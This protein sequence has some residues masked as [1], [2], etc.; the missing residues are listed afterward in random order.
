MHVWQLGLCLLW[1]SSLACSTASELGLFV[2]TFATTTP[3][4]LLHR[5][6]YPSILTLTRADMAHGFQDKLS[7]VAYF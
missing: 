6:T 1:C 3:H 4:F 2:T 5:S 7:A